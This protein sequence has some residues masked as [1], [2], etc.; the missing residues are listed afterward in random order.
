M[1]HMIHAI[2]LA[3]RCAECGECERVCPMDIPV[4][5]L[6]KKINMEMKKLFDYVPGG[7]PRKR[8]RRCSPSRWKRRR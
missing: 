3:G 6:K 7:Q 2:H 4:A 5:K 1:F 8:S